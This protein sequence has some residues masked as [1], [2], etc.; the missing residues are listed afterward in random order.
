MSMSCPAGL[1]LRCIYIVGS[2]MPFTVVK[3]NI[4]SSECAKLFESKKVREHFQSAG[5][6]KNPGWI[7]IRS[8]PLGAGDFQS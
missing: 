1:N 5:H 2:I 7:R 3:I 4:F 6:C 8:G